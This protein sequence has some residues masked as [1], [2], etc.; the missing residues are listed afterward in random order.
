MCIRV[1]KLGSDYERGMPVKSDIET[2]LTYNVLN[3]ISMMPITRSQIKKPFPTS[4]RVLRRAM[5]RGWIIKNCDK[6]E[7]TEDG[8]DKIDIIKIDYGIYENGGEN[9][10]SCEPIDETEWYYI[11]RIDTNERL[12]NKSYSVNVCKE[13][14]LNSMLHGLN[15]YGVTWE[16]ITVADYNEK[17]KNV[18]SVY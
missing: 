15:K 4:W 16:A 9:I 5:E 11:V 12:I 6:Y 2:N 18:G 14:L 1:V 13:R 7:I 3:L 17:F 10:M 8:L